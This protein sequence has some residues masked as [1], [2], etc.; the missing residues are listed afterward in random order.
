MNSG[1][2]LRLCFEAIVGACSASLL[3]LTL[4]W[5]DWI[6]RFVGVHPDGGDGSVEWELVA[7]FS[8]LSVVA[9]GMTWR[10]WRVIRTGHLPS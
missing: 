3:A 10:D 2:R 7:F 8:A 1:L 9:L 6:E 4:V 5:P